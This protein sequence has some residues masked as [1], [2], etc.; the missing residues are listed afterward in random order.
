MGFFCKAVPENNKANKSTEEDFHAAI[1]AELSD[2]CDCF[3]KD[4]E[5]FG[6]QNLTKGETVQQAEEDSSSEGDGEDE[7][8]VWTL[9]H[10][11]INIT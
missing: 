9:T 5:D 2:V 6:C 1:G 4:K 3:N 7:K 11:I 10:N 8:N